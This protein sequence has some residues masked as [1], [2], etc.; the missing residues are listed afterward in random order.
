MREVDQRCTQDNE[1]VIREQVL[2][3]DGLNTV[4][5]EIESTLNSRPITMNSDDPSDLEALTPNH[6]LLMKRKAYLPPGLFSKTDN[7]CR[8]KMETNSVYCKSILESLGARVP[9]HVT[10]TSEMA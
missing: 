10:R 4:F 1:S 6:L 2:D 3:D 5:C 8:S 9:S 7:Y